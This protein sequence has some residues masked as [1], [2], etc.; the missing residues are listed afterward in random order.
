L[1]TRAGAG[2]GPAASHATRIPSGHPEGYLE[3]FAQLYRDVAEQ[4]HARWQG[5]DAN[6]L[7]CTVPGVEDGLRGMQF[8]NAAVAS[9]RAGG[10]WTAVE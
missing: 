9:S 7:A 5:R 8:I 10:R 3:G 4:L 1:I 6:P 2:A